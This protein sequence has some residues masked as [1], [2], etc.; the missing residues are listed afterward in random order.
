[1]HRLNDSE[2]PPGGRSFSGLLPVT[3]FLP[4]QYGI[5]G[6]NKIISEWGIGAE[7]S[8]IIDKPGDKRYVVMGPNKKTPAK[9]GSIPSAVL[10]QPWEAFEEVGFRCVR[11]LYP[12]KN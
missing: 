8:G 10:R 3:D 11:S 2:E 4:N 5:R 9:A 12:D 6:L 7:N 1:M